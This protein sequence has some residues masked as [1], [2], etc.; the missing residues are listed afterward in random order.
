MNLVLIG[1]RGTGKSTV[2]KILA[3]ALGLPYVSLDSRL[4]ERAG[5][6]VPE[7]VKRHSWDHFRDLEEMVVEGYAA[8]DGWVLDT[9]GG[10][11]TRSVNVERLRRDGFVVLLT[12]TIADIEARIGGDTQRPSLTGGKSFVEEIS[13]VLAQREP[14]YRAAAD[15]TVDTSRVSAEEAARE[16]QVEFIRRRTSGRA[17]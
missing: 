4:V 16:I 5:M 12:S 14:L 2:G 3:E 7:I 15:W 1:Y 11:V 17:R 9:G 6:P 13:E 10:V 8:Q